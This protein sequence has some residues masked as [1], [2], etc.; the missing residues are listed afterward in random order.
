[1]KCIYCGTPLSAIDYCTGCGADVTLQKRIVRISNLLYNEGLEKATVRDLSGAISCLK[2]SLKFNKENIDARNLLGLV[3]YETGEVVAA[4]SEWVISKNTAEENNAADFYISR[5]QSNK[6]KLDAINQTIKKYNQALLY[7]RQD[8]EDMAVIQLKK[9]VAQNPNFIKAYHLLAL[10]Y[11][12]QQEFEKAR[13]LLKKAAQIDTTN[14]TTL[15]YSREIEDATGVGTNLTKPA[16]R[17][18]KKSDGEEKETRMF[19]PITYKNGNDT[20]IQPTTFRDSS[21]T[22][23][24][25]NIFLGFVLGA[26]FIWFLAIPANTRKVNQQASQSVTDANT[27]LAS[28]TA[29]VTSLEAEIEEYQQKVDEANETMDAAKKKAEGYDTLLKAAN[30]F[31]GGNQTAAGTT[32]TGIDAESLEGEGKTLYDTMTST[33]KSVMYSAVYSEGATAFA[34]QDYNTAVEKLKQA[35][36]VDPSQYDAWY[37]LSFAY[38]N[39]GDSENADK[40]LAETIVRFPAY[41]ATLTPY[42]SDPS[43][44]SKKK[45]EAGGTSAEEGDTGETDANGGDTVSDAGYTDPNTGYMDPNAG[46]TDSNAGYTDPNAGYTDPNA[47]YTDPNAGGGYYDENGIWIQQ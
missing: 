4:L 40:Y 19:G 9:V 11:M 25:L 34:S 22:A 13:R 7:C 41:E 42:L 29:K 21:T 8:D 37:Y 38:Y 44:L 1:M 45:S 31:L 14:T 12:K 18:K 46:Y 27:K 5:L 33:V 2:R 15:R 35:T 36:E 39:L 16:K 3:Y 10:V 32:L 20:I 28:E 24:F 26:A 47:G 17:F 23:T 30:E 43:V 6:N